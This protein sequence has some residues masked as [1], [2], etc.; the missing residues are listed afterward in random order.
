MKFQSEFLSVIA[1]RGYLHQSADAK[2]LDQLMSSNK[3]TAYIGFD[4]TAKSLHI[5]GLIQIMLLR[6][7][8]KTG[9]KVIVLLG[10]ATTKVGDP[11]G[12]EKTR[13]MLSEQD[14]MENKEGILRVIRKFLP[15]SGDINVVDNAEWL[16]SYKYLDFLVDV[17][18]KFSIN[19]MLGLD[20]VQSRL[21]RDQQLSFLEF[22]YVLLQSYDFVELH[23]RYGCVLQ[24][25]GSDQ[26]GN[27]VSGI[28]LGRRMGCQ[29]L[30]GI[31]T[32]LLLT[33]SGAKMG[34][35]AT[36]AVWLDE[37]MYDPYSYWQYFRNIPDQEVG[38]WLRYFT[39]LPLKEI[40]RL[41]SLEGES[42]NEAKKILAT[43]ATKIC[44][45][46]EKACNARERAEKVFEQ[47][48][49][50]GLTSV[51]I[52]ADLFSNTGGVPVAKL[53]HYTGLE[54]SV[55]AGKRLIKGG[56]CAVNGK[57]VQNVDDVLHCE[58]FRNNGGY[59]TIFCGKKRRLKVVLEE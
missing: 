26:W 52:R 8:Q 3:I 42:I 50:E 39:E 21:K 36:G 14:I 29:Q 32:P 34:K 59:I 55:G 25:G 46:M 57:A 56:G 44:H 7:L 13:S 40:E 27:I 30:Y 12:R 47:R 38:K 35:T 17:G 49:E 51:T 16:C 5:G 19:V 54:S 58:D 24:I 33:S 31:T 6:Y 2:A 43:E 45:G 28:E 48:A 10:G 53:L 4:C 37:S 15:E 23:K 20:S 9:H 18:S 41:E 1:A 22:N 11:S